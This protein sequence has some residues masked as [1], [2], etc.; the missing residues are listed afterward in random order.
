MA[1]SGQTGIYFDSGGYRLLGRLFLARGDDP[2]P[3]AILLH[4]LPGIEQNH[5]LAHA[6]RDYGWNALTFHYRGCWGS[7]GVYDSRTIPDDVIACLDYLSRGDH[8]QVD[9]DRMVLIGH[10]MGGWAAVLAAARDP[11]PRAIGAIGMVGNP[12][13]V[14]FDDPALVEAEFTP[15]LPGLGVDEF[16]K[17]WR[18]LGREA[19]F[20]P[21]EH[22]AQIAPRPLLLIHAE[23]DDVV[24]LAHAREVFERAG[25]PKQW[26][27]HPEANHSFTWHRAWL[28]EQIIEWLDHLSWEPT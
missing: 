13:R 8:P 22:V 16:G 10:S 4:G 18:D 14:R 2:K 7:G 1:H 3:T 15:W 23:R 17:R 5:D 25:E 28:R 6:L 20:N 26:I 24:P 19:G 21:V 9:V 12:A 11:R 27:E